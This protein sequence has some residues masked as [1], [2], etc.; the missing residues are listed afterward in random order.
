MGWRLALRQN[1]LIGNIASPPFPALSLQRVVKQAWGLISKN[2]A[3]AFN[4][5]VFLRDLRLS[6]FFVKIKLRTLPK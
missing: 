5:A 3:S 4:L 1:F 2:T 6:G